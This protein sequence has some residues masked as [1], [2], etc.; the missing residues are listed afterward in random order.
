MI[1]LVLTDHA[2]GTNERACF[3]RNMLLWRTPPWKNKFNDL[4]KGKKCLN[5]SE[6][7]FINRL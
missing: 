5:T 7:K 2:A 4:T 6:N 1:V 3:N